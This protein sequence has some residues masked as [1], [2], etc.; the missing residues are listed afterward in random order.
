VPV[1]PVSGPLE[2]SCEF[3]VGRQLPSLI[4]PN[5]FLRMP[6]KSGLPRILAQSPFS[7]P[8]TIQD[9]AIFV[10]KKRGSITVKTTGRAEAGAGGFMAGSCAP[11]AHPARPPVRSPGRQNAS[12]PVEESGRGEEGIG[13]QGIGGRVDARRCAAPSHLWCPP[14]VV[15]TAQDPL[16]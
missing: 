14:L 7:M 8:P 5:A 3:V 6:V 2:D 16:E 13:T 4:D 15:R 11:A 10:S 12:P 9:Q 1:H